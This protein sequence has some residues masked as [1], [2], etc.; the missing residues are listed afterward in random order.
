MTLVE[1]LRKERDE[2]R[3]AYLEYLEYLGL[4]NRVLELYAGELRKN[5]AT[6]NSNPR[7]KHCL[8]VQFKKDLRHGTES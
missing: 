2:Y 3:K 7:V 8:A 5:T 1:Q 6:T 4:Y